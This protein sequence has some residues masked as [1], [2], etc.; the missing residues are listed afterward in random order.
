MLES[1]CQGG[2]LSKSAVAAWE[3][4]K[5]L[6]EKTI[7]WKTIGDDCLGSRLAMGSMHS[8][9][10]VSY[11]GSKIAILENTLKGLS[12]QTPQTP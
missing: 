8:I 11:L 9:S 2:F 7:Q 5:D 10:N 12:V 1:M 3:F 6:A 4:L